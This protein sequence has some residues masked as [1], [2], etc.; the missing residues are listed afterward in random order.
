MAPVQDIISQILKIIEDENGTNT[1][2]TIENNNQDTW[3][4]T[5]ID[6]ETITTIS[7]AE[8]DTLYSAFLILLEIINE[9]DGPT[10]H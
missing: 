1:L 2:F 9:E 8:S 3:I 6:R 7:V 10:I 4:V 5:A